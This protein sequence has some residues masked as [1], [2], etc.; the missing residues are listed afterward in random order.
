MIWFNR[1]LHRYWVKVVWSFL[2]KRLLS[3]CSPFSWSMTQNTQLELQLVF[4]FHFLH[5]F[6]LLL[7]GQSIESYFRTIRFFSGYWRNWERKTWYK[8]FHRPLPT[9]IEQKNRAV[10]YA[11][12]MLWFVKA[13]M[14]PRFVSLCNIPFVLDVIL[15][16]PCLHW[17]MLF[18]RHACIQFAACCILWAM[19]LICLSCLV[20]SWSCCFQC[21]WFV[22]FKCLLNSQEPPCP[23]DDNNV[24]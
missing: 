10:L 22:L 4:P 20:C 17:L 14:C 9:K 2:C 24:V 7:V 1:D 19:S 3:G 18:F 16:C 12:P 5:R 13:Y 21:A 8:Y 23:L 6:A 15:L 11:N